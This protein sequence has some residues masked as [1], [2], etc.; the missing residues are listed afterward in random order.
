MRQN[1]IDG[2]FSFSVTIIIVV[3]EYVLAFVL[4]QELGWNR[5]ILVVFC[6]GTAEPLPH[7]SPITTSFLLVFMVSFMYS[8]NCFPLMST[9]HLMHGK[10]C[11][12]TNLL[13]QTC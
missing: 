7:T 8:L 1:Y 12:C 3:R 11:I 6:I 10:F 4:E 9:Q 2:N 13:F 5:T